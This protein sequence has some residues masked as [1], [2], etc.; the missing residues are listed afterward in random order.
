MRLLQK[1]ESLNRSNKNLSKSEKSSDP[2]K[3]PSSDTTVTKAVNFKASME[4][5]QRLKNKYKNNISKTSLT[6]NILLPTFPNPLDS[7]LSKW[8]STTPSEVES[9]ER[10][11]KMEKH[12]LLLEKNHNLKSGGLQILENKKEVSSLRT[13]CPLMTLYSLRTVRFSP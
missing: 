12:W 7:N 5:P 8:K 10:I 4:V 6:L 13:N 9:L 3:S 11:L 1:I 2:I